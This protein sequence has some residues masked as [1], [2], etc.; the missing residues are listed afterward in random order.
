[1]PTRPH[2][3][4]GRRGLRAQL[5]L[6]HRRLYALPTRGFMRDPNWEAKGWPDDLVRGDF[7]YLPIGGQAMRVDRKARGAT[8]TLD[9][10][11]DL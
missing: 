5:E 8:A 1:M 6:T 7:L 11:A 10:S 9:P 2:R 3:Y 4:G